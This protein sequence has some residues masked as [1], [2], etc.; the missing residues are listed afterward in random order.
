MGL[1]AVVLREYVNMICV[2][3][4]QSE[5][6]WPRSAPRTWGDRF[7][8]RYMYCLLGYLA[9]CVSTFTITLQ[10][11]QKGRFDRRRRPFENGP[12]TLLLYM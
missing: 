1:A 7:A 9:R 4:I 2:C 11:A 6:R 5:S 3:C 8:R 10:M 12:W